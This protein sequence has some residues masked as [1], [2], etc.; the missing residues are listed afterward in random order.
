MRNKV[1]SCH[2]FVE[3]DVPSHSTAQ[4]IECKIRIPPPPFL[5]VDLAKVMSMLLM[6][7]SLNSFAG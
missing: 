3:D 4:N 6:S 5:G 1:Y 7:N 2:V